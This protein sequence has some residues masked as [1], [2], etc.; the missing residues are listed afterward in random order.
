VWAAAGEEGV[1][2]TV[3]AISATD[4]Q[5]VLALIAIISL[6][7]GALVYT[8]KNNS[9]GKDIN[10][11]VNNVGPG[12]H[13]LIDLI[14]QIKDKQEEFDKKWG[15]LPDDMDDAVGLVELIHGMDKRISGIQG[16]LREHVAW[17]MNAKYGNPESS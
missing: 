3:D 12:E 1:R 14:K 10:K 17:E 16:E 8:I 15:N 4:D 11:A 13:H 7:I 5:I 6:S 2:S 9:L